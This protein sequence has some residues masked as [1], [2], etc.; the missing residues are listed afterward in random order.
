M[1]EID[2][3][4]SNVLINEIKEENLQK[5]EINEKI[6]QEINKIENNNEKIN[7]TKIEE[8][9]D[10]WVFVIVAHSDDQILG[11]GGTIAKYAKE[12]KKILTIIFSYGV[13]SN[14]HFKKEVIKDIRIDEAREAD[15]V[16]NGTGVQFFNLSEGKFLKEF[17]EKGF[18]EILSKLLL[19]FNP[20]KIIT[21]AE[22]DSLPDHKSVNKLVLETYDKLNKEKNFNT[23]IYTFGVWRFFKFTQRWKPRLVVDI[24][25]TF[26]QKISALKE[27][28]SQ[29]D[30]MLQL[31]W[32]VYLKAFWAGFKHN[33]FL[34][35][36]FYKVR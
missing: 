10:S 8:K 31:T 7:E 19:Q 5:R 27:F 28:K 34:A 18:D 36:E 17:H 21:H 23:E 1:N 32:S 16:V 15:K 26:E 22:D 14:P 3:N 24:S 4:S 29:W 13:F 2:N 11:P 35:E 30:S 25:E 33:L 6:N 9:K 12:G 20:E